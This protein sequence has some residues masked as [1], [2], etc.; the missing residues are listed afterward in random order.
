MCSV[1]SQ[2]G[3][4]GLNWL[5]NVISS[6]PDVISVDGFMQNV[7]SVVSP[8][9]LKESYISLPVHEFFHPRN[10]DGL[11]VVDRQYALIIQIETK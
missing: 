5:G 2:P 3:N 6:T 8:W 10:R 9:L 4:P 7:I 1:V 11:R